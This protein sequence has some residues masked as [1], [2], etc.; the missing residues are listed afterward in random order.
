MRSTLAALA[1]LSALVGPAMA[2]PPDA[3][4]LVKRMKA[5]LEPARPGARR[6]TLTLNQEGETVQVTI[7]EARKQVND[8]WRILLTTLAPAEAV[9]TS[10]LVQAG[11]PGQDTEWLYLPYVRRVRK[12]VSPEAYSA[13]L[14][15]DF[16]Y[17]DLGFVSTGATYTLLGA[18]AQDGV[19]TYRIQGVPKENW[20]YSRWVT[21]IN[22][23]TAMPIMR[24]IYDSAN[25][26]WKRQRWSGVT[27]VDGVSLPA[28]I[29]M[30]DVQ[31]KSRTDIRLTGADYDVTL[32]DALFDPDQLPAAATASVWA[33]VGK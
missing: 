3:Q 6:L 18:G 33:G 11:G 25:R 4:S 19:K 10:Y 14:N 30:E 21:T 2:G 22:A 7:G 9:G 1:I 26:L 8:A 31:A 20:Y 15:S 28:E 23:D 13:F 24:E 27:V 16:T 29:S 32:P 17:A 5:A 12:F